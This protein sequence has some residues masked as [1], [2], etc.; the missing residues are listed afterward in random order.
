MPKI[1]D[2][3]KIPVLIEL[4]ITLDN[5][6]P[7]SISPYTFSLS[8]FPWYPTLLELSSNSLF[9][10]CKCSYFS[11]LGL[12]IGVSKGSFLNSS[13][14]SHFLWMIY[15]HRFDYYLSSEDFQLFN[16]QPHPVPQASDVYLQLPVR[17]QAGILDV[18]QASQTQYVQ[19]GIHL[20][21]K[22][23]A[24]QLL[25]VSIAGSVL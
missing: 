4:S 23:G 6:N 13:Y 20:F 25:H 17:M 16:L 8:G 9:S 24:S 18:P 2:Y 12:N 19:N 3:L 11:Q 10:K 22:P 21:P 7:V 1:N 14:S 15:F 5:I